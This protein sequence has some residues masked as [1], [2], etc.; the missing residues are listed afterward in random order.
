MVL[1]WVVAGRDGPVYEGRGNPV[2]EPSSPATR[3]STAQWVR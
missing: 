1:L 2:P 3:D